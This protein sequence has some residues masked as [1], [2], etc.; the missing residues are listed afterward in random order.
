[1]DIPDIEDACTI[2]VPLQDDSGVTS[3]PMKVERKK[4]RDELDIVNVI[5]WHCNAQPDE[6]WFLLVRRPDGGKYFC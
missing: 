3:Y 5:E 2:C 1:V 6:R 4:S